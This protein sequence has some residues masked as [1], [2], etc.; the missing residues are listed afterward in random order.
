MP[1]K[2]T[3]LRR[4]LGISYLIMAVCAQDARKTGGLRC[5]DV[6]LHGKMITLD[7]SKFSVDF[8]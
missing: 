6:A 3:A 5:R 4:F 7:G 2:R 8:P 1:S